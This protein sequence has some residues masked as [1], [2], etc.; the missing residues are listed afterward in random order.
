MFSPL[1][2]QCRHFD[3]CRA[4]TFV[5]RDPELYMCARII[6][7]EMLRLFYGHGGKV[8]KSKQKRHIRNLVFDI[9]R[10]ASQI[11]MN[12]ELYLVASLYIL[13]FHVVCKLFFKE[14]KNHQVDDIN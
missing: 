8:K 13:Q 1:F 5:I 14:K 6:R 12:L 9:R 7:N 11:D 2:S 4:K 10:N 3:A